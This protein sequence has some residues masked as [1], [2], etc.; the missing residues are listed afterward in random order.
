MGRYWSLLRNWSGTG[1]CLVVLGQYGALLVG[2]WWNWDSMGRFWLVLGGN[3]SVGAVLV[4]NW[5]NWVV[6]GR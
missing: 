6:K 3:E 5:W 1:W 4:G 2:T